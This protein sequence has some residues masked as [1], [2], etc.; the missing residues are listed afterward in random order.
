M[1][2]VDHSSSPCQPFLDPIPGVMP[3]G[4]ICTLAG[5]SGVGKNAMVSGWVARWL[6]GKTICGHATNKPIAIGMLAGDRRWRSHRIWLDVAGV[7]ELPHYS[8]RDDKTFQ[9]RML[10]N[11]DS[12]LTA[13]NLALDRLNLPPGGLLIADPLSLWLPGKI[14]D[15]KDVAI[16]LGTLD[17]VLHR[18]QLTCLGIFHQSKSKNDVKQ[19]YSRPQDRILGSAAQLGFSD[20]TMYL[21]SPED[22]DQPYY[23]LGW[24]PHNAPA[25]THYFTRTSTGLFQIHYPPATDEAV[26]SG[27]QTT[28]ERA[29]IIMQLLP[30]EGG[31]E[32]HLWVKRVA[33]AGLNIS[34]KTFQRDVEWLIQQGLVQRDGYGKYSRRKPS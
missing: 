11:A 4:S 29:Q 25:E 3:F 27:D 17:Q 30:E 5:A 9:W 16:G 19:N 14:N 6:A 20:T 23:G 7:G 34:L 12:T 33:D 22:L 13:L 31:I 26:T 32:R 24:I 10:R 21:L 1:A 8:L 18:R 15:Y 28:N 2:T